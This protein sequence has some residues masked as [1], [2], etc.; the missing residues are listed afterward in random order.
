MHHIRRLSAFISGHMPFIVP[1]CLVLGI[2]FPQVL[3]PAKAAV[4]YLFAII[5]FQGSLNT[6]LHQVAETFRRPRELL[7]ILSVTVV[8]MPALARLAAGLIFSDPGIITGIVV[9]YSIPIAVMSFMW[10]DMYRGNASLGLAAILISTVL[11]PVTLPLAL[12]VLMGASVTVDPWSMVGDL[13]FMIALPAIA[14]VAVNE[15]SKGWGHE[16]LAPNLGAFTRLFSVF[17]IA[18]NSTGLAPYVRSFD[19]LVLEV[20]VFICV[21]ATLGFVLGLGMARFLGLSVQDMLSMVFCVGLR[22][23]SSGSVI[24]TQFFPGSAIIPVMAGT[25]FQQILAA[26]FGSLVQHL[27]GEERER[28][29]KRV[30]LARLRERGKRE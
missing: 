27:T 11:A 22:N 5:T 26:V 10:I 29:H 25:L 17:V 30:R 20:A 18:C 4:P 16:T 7:A 8:L 23:I 24:V 19:P 13:V 15:L 28:Q 12:R 1:V 3:G 6:S 2:A 9:E 21:F 14:G